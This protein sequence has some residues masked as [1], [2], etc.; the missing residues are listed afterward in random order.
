MLDTVQEFQ[1]RTNDRIAIG[2]AGEVEEVANLACYLVSDYANYMN[3]AV[4]SIVVTA[5]DLLLCSSFSDIYQD[6][7]G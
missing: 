2:R 1:V 6:R 3:G 7:P 5:V 4:R